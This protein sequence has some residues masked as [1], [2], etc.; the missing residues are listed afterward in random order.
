MSGPQAGTVV[1]GVCPGGMQGAECADD[2]QLTFVA[3]D[4]KHGELPLVSSFE[5]Q[6][7]TTLPKHFPGFRKVDASTQP[8]ADGT[9][10]LRYEF[11]AGAKREVLGVFRG[12]DGSGV[13][14]VVVGPAKAVEHH[15][16]ELDA[17]LSGASADA[18]SGDAAGAH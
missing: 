18:S 4:G 6:L 16:K 14:A 1:S 17:F 9:R 3:Y 12:S 7:D 8:A 5:E 2:V 11:T 15:A 13:V 10:W